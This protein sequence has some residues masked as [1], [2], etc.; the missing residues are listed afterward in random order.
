MSFWP[1]PT[2]LLTDL[3]AASALGPVVEIGA[4]TGRLSARLRGAGLRVVALDRVA[5]G[6]RG[7]ESAVAADARELPFAAQTLGACI[8]ANVLRHQ[9][10]APRRQIARACADALH[11][12]GRVVVLEDHP[13]A[14]DT[15]ERN[16]RDVIALLARFDSTRG[17]V[18]S[19]DALT[20][21]LREHFGA[22]TEMG[23][24]E[25]EDTV[26]DALAP[27]RWMRARGAA[28][29]SVLVPASLLD[30]LERSVREH[31]MRYGRYSFCVFQ[32]PREESLH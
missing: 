18:R 24:L 22:P 25:N 5:T 17:D 14:R 13:R 27:L 9:S 16:Y 10:E 11:P 3:R 30:E 8:L 32:R 6:L 20:A 21:E 26:E 23:D 4:G 12:H 15:S 31:G 28:A 19:L 29:G 1:F 7:V 2:T